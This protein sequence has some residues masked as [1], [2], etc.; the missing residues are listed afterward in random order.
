VKLHLLLCKQKNRNKSKL[1]E[2]TKENTLQ[3]DNS[4]TINNSQK[5]TNSST[6]NRSNS[7]FKFGNTTPTLPDTPIK[8]NTTTTV[9]AR[10]QD[11]SPIVFGRG[12]IPQ[13]RGGGLNITHGRGIGL[14]IR[15]MTRKINNTIKSNNATFTIPP[16]NIPLPSAELNNPYANN[17]P[18]LH[19]HTNSD[20][21]LL[22]YKIN[23]ENKYSFHIHIRAKT[24]KPTE[25]L[26]IESLTEH[27]LKSF[28]K[29]N[30]STKLLSTPSKLTVFTWTT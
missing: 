14:Q 10:T 23:V 6:I 15:T 7:P 24:M 17:T 9:N 25:D 21:N 20:N 27:I 28:I 5:Q 8:N 2:N 22:P 13:G 16:S 29:S 11:R 19:Q 18:E 26:T 1:K 4:N 30:K 3:S 12:P